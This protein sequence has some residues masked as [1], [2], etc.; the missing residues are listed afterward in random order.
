MNDKSFYAHGHI[1]MAAIRVL[2]QQKTEVSPQTVSQILQISLEQT[3]L[4]CKKLDEHGIV[5]MISS[6]AGDRLFIR[7]HQQIEEFSDAEETSLQ[8]EI[9]NFR[10]S[11]TQLE[12]KASDFQSEKNERQRQLFADIEA[13][14]KKSKT[15]E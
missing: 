3:Y 11:Q 14:L 12:Q 15:K 1:V 5:E 7:K 4:I 8:D 2:K 13:R 10:N 9:N 6:T